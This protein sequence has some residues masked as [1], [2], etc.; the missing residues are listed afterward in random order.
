MVTQCDVPS[1]TE[2]F[3]EMVKVVNLMLHLLYQDLK[4][5]EKKEKD[6][7]KKEE[8]KEE[9]KKKRRRSWSWG[10]AEAFRGVWM[11]AEMGGAC[12]DGQGDSLSWDSTACLLQ[13]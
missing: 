9:Q 13:R 11:P 3:T 5:K 8:K 10:I 7:E 12:R 6:K 1:A 4:K 2:L